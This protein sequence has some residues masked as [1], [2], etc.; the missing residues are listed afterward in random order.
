MGGVKG[1]AKN[2]LLFAADLTKRAQ[3]LKGW[4][5]QNFYMSKKNKLKK[6]RGLECEIRTSDG[7]GTCFDFDCTMPL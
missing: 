6:L 3:T 7:F 2:S 5:P 1:L 4:S